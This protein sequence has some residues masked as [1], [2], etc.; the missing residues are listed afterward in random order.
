[1]LHRSKKSSDNV[2]SV[3][4]FLD[5]RQYLQAVFKALK[6]ANSD[7][8][9]RAFARMAGSTSPNFLQLILAH[10]PPPTPRHISLLC[11][12]LRLSAAEAKQFRQL[13]AFDRATTVEEKDI[14]IRTILRARASYEARLV[15][16]EQHE[17]YS[18]W[19]HSVVRAVVGYCRIKKGEEDFDVIGRSIH[20]PLSGVRIKESLRLLEKLDLIGVDDEG[21]YALRDPVITTGDDIRSLQ[22]ARFQKDTMKLAQK[23]LENCP[24]VLRDISTL[25]LHISGAGFAEIRD[26][27]RAFRK[28]IIAVASRDIGDDRVYQLN[29]QLFPLTQIPEELKK[30]ARP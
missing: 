22:V 16:A 2:P 13:V 21:Y 27:V 3:F 7:F 10:T 11:R 29:L 1:M 5:F 12:G 24:A 20:P 18:C 4:E 30:G 17:Y 8:S 14:R 23:A 25:T 26:R 6:Q 28:E 19:Y 15:G 9:Y